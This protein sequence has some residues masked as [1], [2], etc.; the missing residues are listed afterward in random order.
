MRS[1]GLA[2]LTLAV[3]TG[4]GPLGRALNTSIRALIPERMRARAM[5]TVRRHVLYGAPQP[6]DEG[7][8]VELRQRY[9]PEVVALSEYLERD[10][11]G[12]WGYDGLA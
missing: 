5:R 4:R 7:L 10:L 3:R 11:M 12:L 6:P 2:R 1:V 9:A 8:M